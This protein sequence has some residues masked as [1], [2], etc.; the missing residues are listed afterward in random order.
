V[1]P[2]MP[3]VLVTLASCVGDLAPVSTTVSKTFAEFRRTHQDTW[4]EDMM[5]FDEDQKSILSD[6]LISASYYA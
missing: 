3:E 6:L 5:M 2:W 1:P 4:R